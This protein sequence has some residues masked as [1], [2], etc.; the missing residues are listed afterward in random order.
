MLLGGCS[1]RA[2]PIVQF[3]PD[4]PIPATIELQSVPFF[5][6]ARYQCGPAALATILS[7][8]G[9]ETSA[10]ALIPH[11]YLPGR[12]GSLRPDL[13]ATTR[14]FGRL[15]YQLEGTL[16]AVLAELAAGQPVLVMQNLGFDWFAQ[17]HYAV[18][19][20]YDLNQGTVILRSGEQR[21]YVLPV[22]TFVKTWE[23]AGRWA[24][25]AA[26]PEQIPVTAQ[27]LSYLQVVHDAEKL[28]PELAISAYQQA[29]GRW[30]QEALLWLA[31]GNAF[32]QQK[33]FQRSSQTFAT[34]LDQH[35]ANAQ[36]WNNYAYAL[37]AQGCPAEALTA[38]RCAVRLQPQNP[39]FRH[40][41][42]ELGDQR[43]EGRSVHV[44]QPFAAPQ[45]GEQS[46]QARLL[47]PQSGIKGSP[48]RF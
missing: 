46:C 25:V 35:P 3:S 20:G 1:F 4:S 38:I 15:P 37:S 41:L 10:D 48:G 12:R 6:Q 18:M 24:L 47:C 43:A 30:P 22:A 9:V 8:S 29:L 17:W 16:E 33:Q 14:R 40:S 36:L 27:P 23:R 44:D 45:Y 34:A 5:P 31:L 7:A 28:D 19:V 2:S 21:R 39:A 26:S 32:Y 13:I 42:I 11:V